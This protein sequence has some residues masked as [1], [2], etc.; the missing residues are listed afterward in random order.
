M[1]TNE[2]EEDQS[3][4][5]GRAKLVPSI[6]RKQREGALSPK[7]VV[8]ADANGNCNED[9]GLLVLIDA[10]Q[11]KVF[12][13]CVDRQGAGDASK[14]RSKHTKSVTVT[15]TSM[16]GAL[17]TLISC[18][19]VRE[20]RREDTLIPQPAQ[21]MLSNRRQKDVNP[22]CTSEEKRADAFGC[23]GDRCDL[24]R[25]SYATILYRQ[26]CEQHEDIFLS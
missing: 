22:V 25:R 1:N 19:V 10:L 20:D 23:H 2:S 17:Y 14:K 11:S 16:L 21:Q 26:Q 18:E 24:S 8:V 13:D 15:N 5:Q 12:D 4:K 3:T 7:T 9:C 6:H